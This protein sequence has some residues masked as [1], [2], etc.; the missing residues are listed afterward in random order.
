MRRYHCA[1]G[2]L[3]VL[4]CLGAIRIPSALAQCGNQA[5][6][7]GRVVPPTPVVL[8]VQVSGTATT[9]LVKWNAVA[10]ATKYYL[11]VSITSDFY[12]TEY[13]PGFELMDVGNVTSTAISG[14]VCGLLVIPVGKMMRGVPAGDR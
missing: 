4:V 6:G 2:S 14:L 3:L 5:S 8:G 1:F 13:V 11:D 10:G 9:T 12:Y 7:P